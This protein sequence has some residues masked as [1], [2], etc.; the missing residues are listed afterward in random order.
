M[1][2]FYSSVGLVGQPVYTSHNTSDLLGIA[3]SH[4]HMFY[5]TSPFPFFVQI[6]H[7]MK[8]KRKCLLS[9]KKLCTLSPGVAITSVQSGFR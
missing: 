9:H 5:F 2:S 8:T 1:T 4:V 7:N 3:R 6:W